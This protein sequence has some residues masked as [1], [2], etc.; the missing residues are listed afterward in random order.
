MNNGRNDMTGRLVIVNLQNILTKIRL[1]GL[2]AR[3]LKGSI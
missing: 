3:S 2:N 1:D